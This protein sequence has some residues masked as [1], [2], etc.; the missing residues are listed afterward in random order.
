MG[1]VKVSETLH[2]ELRTASRA[3]RRSI[4]LQAEHWLRL[5]MLAERYPHLACTDLMRL[6]LEAEQVNGGLPALLR[7]AAVPSA[8]A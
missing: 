3:F 2:D 4:N 8:A 7:G 6:L 5:G 1:M